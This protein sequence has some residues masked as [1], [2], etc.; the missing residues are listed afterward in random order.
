VRAGERSYSAWRPYMAP[1]K[2]VMCLAVVLMLA[3]AIAMLIKDIAK[4][5]DVE[6]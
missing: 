3:Q 5:R 4:L 1:I 6:L 2:I